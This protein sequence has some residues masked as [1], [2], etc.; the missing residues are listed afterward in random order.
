[1]LWLGSIWVLGLITQGLNFF[2]LPLLLV[3]WTVYAGFLACLGLWFS[4]VCKTTLR[5]FMWTLFFALAAGMGH[6]LIWMCCIPLGV[7]G[8]A[9]GSAM[10]SVAEFQVGLSPPLALGACFSFHDLEEMND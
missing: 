5:A 6:W 3:A 9:G 2:A 4:T 1:W 10:L 7:G 8:G